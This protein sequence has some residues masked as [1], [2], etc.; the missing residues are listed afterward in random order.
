MHTDFCNPVWIH[1]MK[2][3]DMIGYD[4]ERKLTYKGNQNILQTQKQSVRLH[5]EEQ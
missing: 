3:N 5:E 2:M 4:R 1:G